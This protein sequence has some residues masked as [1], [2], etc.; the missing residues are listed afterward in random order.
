MHLSNFRIIFSR[1]N[2]TDE[3]ESKNTR[4]WEEKKLKSCDKNRKVGEMSNCVELNRVS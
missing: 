4:K 3:Y 2:S 1:S